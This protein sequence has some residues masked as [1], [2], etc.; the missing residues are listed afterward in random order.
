MSDIFASIDEVPP[1]VPKNT[2]WKYR[3]WLKKIISK[4][5]IQNQSTGKTRPRRTAP[6]H[7]VVI[8]SLGSLHSPS[9]RNITTGVLQMERDMIIMFNSKRMECYL[10]VLQFFSINP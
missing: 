4:R 7:I 5:E 10:S 2:E 6:Q 1:E 3:G 9:E 8:S